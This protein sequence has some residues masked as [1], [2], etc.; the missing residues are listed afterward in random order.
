MEHLSSEIQQQQQRR[1]R[2]RR[3]YKL[4]WL[5]YYIILMLSDLPWSFIVLG[6]AVNMINT[7]RRRKRSN[8]CYYLCSCSSFHCI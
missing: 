6:I 4:N 1:P 8:Y 3:P 5:Q 2:Y 7:G